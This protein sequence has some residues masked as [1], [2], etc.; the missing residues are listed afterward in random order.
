[1]GNWGISGD[2]RVGYMSQKAVVFLL[3]ETMECVIVSPHQSRSSDH[4]AASPWFVVV[5][6]VCRLAVD[7][8]PTV[9]S[10]PDS[11]PVMM[12]CSGAEPPSSNQHTHAKPLTSRGGEETGRISGFKL[13]ATV[14]HQQL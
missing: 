1:M 8:S 12:R 11:L 7:Y 2:N 6:P 14:L 13:G 5:A 3:Q 4:S 10:P 9:I